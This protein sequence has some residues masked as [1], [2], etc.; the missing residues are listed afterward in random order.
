M[1]RKIV[2]V[3]CAVALMLS[4]PVLAWA[5]PSPVLG[6]NGAGKVN[7]VY[8]EVVASAG[9]IESVGESAKQASNVKLAGNDAVVASFE[10]IG[11]ATNVGLAFSV[12]E[13]W[14]GYTFK[15]FIEHNDGSTEV[16]TATV[17]SDG[18]LSLRV[19]KLSIFTLVAEGASTSPKTGVN[20]GA[21]S[22][23]VAGMTIAMAAA[24]VFVATALRR[25]ATQ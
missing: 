22:G 13:K 8:L 3:V 16:K 25:K 19:D 11:D 1:K 20:I 15:V 6:S 9:T 12:G 2:S 24:A 5:A 17:G 10:I 18:L 14:A 21:T 7:D 4:L 23:A